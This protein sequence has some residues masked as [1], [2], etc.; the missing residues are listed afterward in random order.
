MVDPR[1]YVYMFFLVTCFII[2]LFNYNNERG[3]KII[4]LLLFFSVLTDG[5]AIAIKLLKINNSNHYILYHF[6]TPLWFTMVMYYY[7]RHIGNA[8]IKKGFYITVVIFCL[9]SAAISLKLVVVSKYPSLNNQIFYVLIIIA[10][11]ITML[12][13]NPFEDKK[14]FAKAVFWVTLGFTIYCSG[15]F[16]FNSLYNYLKQKNPLLARDTFNL[17]NSIFNDILYTLISIGFICSRMHRK[18]L[19]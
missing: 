3:L 16:T 14:L 9:L 7:T 12:N 6:F 2:S 13:I 17:I 8:A 5:T 18:F 15:I 10:S 1:S 11:V 19:Q 4:S